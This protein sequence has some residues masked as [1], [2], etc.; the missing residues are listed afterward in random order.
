MKELQKKYLSMGVS[1]YSVPVTPV[2]IA[3]QNLTQTQLSSPHLNQIQMQNYLLGG[4]PLQN[5]SGTN[6]EIFFI[7]WK[8]S[9]YKFSM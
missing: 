9:D 8:L 3:Q 7:P 5:S 4:L 1:P 6:Y 2:T